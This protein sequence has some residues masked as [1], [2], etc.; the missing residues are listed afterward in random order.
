MVGVKALRNGW[1]LRVEREQD[2]A[3]GDLSMPRLVKT[4]SDQEKGEKAR[5]LRQVKAELMKSKQQ[6]AA[7]EKEKAKLSAKPKKVENEANQVD[8]HL[9]IKTHR[10]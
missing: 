2:R 6:V 9:H 4:R 5:A 8:A 10:L 7:V 1:S 3:K